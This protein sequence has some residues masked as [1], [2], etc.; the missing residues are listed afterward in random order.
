MRENRRKEGKKSKGGKVKLS[1]RV[2]C[3]KKKTK[4]DKM[5]QVF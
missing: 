3:E 1:N 5:P 2:T 4:A